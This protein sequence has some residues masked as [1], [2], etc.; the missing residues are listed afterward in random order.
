MKENWPGSGLGEHYNYCWSCCEQPAATARIQRST[1]LMNADWLSW[2]VKTTRWSILGSRSGL[3]ACVL[4]EALPSGFSHLICVEGA[5][6]GAKT[7]VAARSPGTQYV[8]PACSH[9][10]YAECGRSFGPANRQTRCSTQ[11]ELS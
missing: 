1:R 7:R 6:F 3:A 9:L 8:N 4:H 5:F 11:A 2:G 10:V